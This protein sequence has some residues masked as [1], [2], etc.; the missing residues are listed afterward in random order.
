MRE[1]KC[2]GCIMKR[3]FPQRSHTH[4][5]EEL[6]ERFF[7]NSLPRNWRS[8]RPEGDYGVDRKVD[9]FDGD[10]ATGLELLVQLKSSQTSQKS[11]YETFQ[12]RI[13]TYNYLRDKLQVVMLV[14]YIDEEKEAY[15]LLLKDVPEPNQGQDTFSVRIPKTNR[16]SSID[17]E[18]TQEYIR[19]ITNKKLTVGRRSHLRNQGVI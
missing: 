1:L 7:I 11:E 15:W 6:S 5:L 10:N 4:Q 9:I 3:Q 14:K 2:M 18:Q 13:A 8:D 17:W 12:L 19:S 16:I